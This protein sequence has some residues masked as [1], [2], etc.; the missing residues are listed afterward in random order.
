MCLARSTGISHSRVQVTAP[1][2]NRN[3][4]SKKG[5]K[6]NQTVKYFPREFLKVPLK[7]QE[8]RTRHTVCESR[9]NQ[10]SSHPTSSRIRLA[11]Q[12]IFRTSLP[13]SLSSRH[14]LESR[15]A[16]SKK[17]IARIPSAIF[18]LRHSSVPIIDQPLSG[19]SDASSDYSADVS[20]IS[21]E[22]SDAS[23]SDRIADAAFDS[24]EE[25]KIF[26]VDK[27]RIIGWLCGMD[28]WDFNGKNDRDEAHTKVEPEN[29]HSPLSMRRHLTGLDS[30]IEFLGTTEEHKESTNSSVEEFHSTESPT[31][32]SGSVIIYDPNRAL[33][34]VSDDIQ[35]TGITNSK[36]AA[37][38]D[39]LEGLEDQPRRT[40][41]Q[42]G[43]ALME[44]DGFG[45]HEPDYEDDVNML[46]D[47][48]EERLYDYL[49]HGTVVGTWD[50][51]KRC[52]KAVDVLEPKKALLRASDKPTKARRRFHPYA[53]SAGS[54][55]NKESRTTS[56][57]PFVDHF[58]NYE[59]RWKQMN[60]DPEQTLTFADIPWPIFPIVNSPEDVTEDRIDDFIQFIRFSGDIGFISQPLARLK[61][62][63]H[64]ELLKRWCL[65]KFT[66][67]VLPRII[68]PK[69]KQSVRFA[70]STVEGYLTRLKNR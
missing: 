59:L 17:P 18:I 34:L 43:E 51:A 62:I 66:K 47:D 70:A 52:L 19:A 31:D 14:S 38:L 3:Q 46:E 45:C 22:L 25:A 49:V 33:A 69:E 40:L 11:L 36:E 28:N 48:F 68:D 58:S 60:D 32:L 37:I 7:P 20:S 50:I 2:R 24:E 35:R 1:R 6:D 44:I 55:S 13:E 8:V 29:T 9:S 56:T 54:H 41:I 26:E 5:Q 10:L 30:K 15:D 27:A 53:R 67:S 23:E 39:Q 57:D 12:E 64:Y 63:V 16:K 42:S 21:T 61:K 4:T 65:D